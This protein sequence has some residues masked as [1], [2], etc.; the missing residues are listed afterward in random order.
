MEQSQ[1]KGKLSS[2]YKQSENK[3]IEKTSKYINLGVNSSFDVGELAYILSE[4]EYNDLTEIANTDTAKHI[5]TLTETIS[6]LRTDIATLTDENNKLKASNNE[7]VNTVGANETELSELR[8]LIQQKEKELSKYTAI[9]V[10][11]LQQKATELETENKELNKQLG[12]KTDYIVYLEQL[13][14]DYKELINYQ[15]NKKFLTPLLNAIGLTDIAKPQ[16][17]HLDMKGHLIT[18]KNEPILTQKTETEPKSE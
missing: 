2:Y 17:K 1:I 3:T 8:Q 14:T 4:T 6:E 13:Q 11:T 16:L 7:L 9:D 18:S 12:I 15:R 5:A 10:E